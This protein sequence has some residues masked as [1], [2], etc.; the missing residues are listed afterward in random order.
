VLINLHR[1][2]AP[3]VSVS[4]WYLMHHKSIATCVLALCSTL[5]VRGADPVADEIVSIPGWTDPFRSK[6]YSGFLKGSDITRR[7]SYFFV[8]SEADP[9]NDP[10]ILWVSFGYII[11]Y[12]I[13]SLYHS[14]ISLIYVSYDK[15]L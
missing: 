6:R 4:F 2:L 13:I 9:E 3:A 1:F 10:V 5:A 14:S 11:F 8:E 15:W 12:H 7:I